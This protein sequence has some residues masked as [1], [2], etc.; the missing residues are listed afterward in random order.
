M[1]RR[2]WRG[3]RAMP[4]GKATPLALAADERGE[5]EKLVRRRKTAQDL[6]LR[7]RIVLRCAAGVTNQAV[8]REAGVCAHTVGKW[9][10]RFAKDRLDGLRDEPRSGAPRT[11]TDQR[12][13][14]LLVRTLE[15]A[16][17]DATHWSTRSMAAT[18]GLS[19]ATVQRVWR[20]FGLK[21]HR[22]EGFQLSADPEFAEKVRDIV[23]LYLSPPDRALVLC[24]D[25]KTE[26]QALERAQPV[27]P[28]RPG[29]PERRAS[30]YVRHGTSSLF[31]ALDV[32]A[33]K[34]IGRCYRRH[35][36]EEFR[37]FLDAVDAAVAPEAEVHLVLD[38]A[39]IHK[40]PP[41]RDWLAKRPRYQ[42]HFTPTSSSWLNQVERF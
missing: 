31:A 30:G 27:L 20:A 8:A 21:P 12:V 10:E 29:Q 41:I 19:P 6:A 24:V 37:D 4:K 18:C 25:E 3:G 7:A 26:M 35:R 42:L 28:M 16:P 39:S 33:G 15:T 17:E 14:E 40:A 36:A 1:M 34:L 9:R 5:L 38:N 22:T 11:V 32:A 2:G 23:G 13:A